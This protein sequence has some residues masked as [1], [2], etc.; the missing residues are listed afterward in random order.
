[1]QLLNKKNNHKESL[2]KFNESRIFKPPDL[3]EIV[4]DDWYNFNKENN[5][6][7]KIFFYK[8]IIRK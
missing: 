1:M 7:S 6:N 3:S 5:P 4:L 8:G 2:P